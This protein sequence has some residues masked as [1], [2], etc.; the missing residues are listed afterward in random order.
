MINII[1]I[2][3]KEMRNN[4]FNTINNENSYILGLILLNI[5]SINENKVVIS[6]DENILNNKKIKKIL[7]EISTN[8]YSTAKES[9][10][11]LDIDILKDIKRH[12]KSDNLYESRIDLIIDENKLEDIIGLIRIYFEY[13]GNI[14]KRNDKSYV[15][16]SS[17]NNNIIKSIKSKFNIPCSVENIYELDLFTLIYNDAN[18]IDLL[19]NIYSNINDN[20]VLMSLYNKYLN[21]INDTKVIQTINVYK[22]CDMAILPSKC[23]ESDAGYDLTII[24]EIKKFNRITTLYDTG[25]KLDIPNGYYVEVFPR[26]SLSKSGYMLANSVGIID[27][28]YKGNIMIAL[29]KICQES[30]DIVLPFKCCQMILKKQIYSKIKETRKELEITERNIGGFGSTNN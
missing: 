4:Y 19:G 17:T 7:R 24:S 28:G 14:E 15:Y 27:Q 6:I 5:L 2:V 10:F 20:Y 12:I 29:T 3:N 18:C 1:Y 26:S 13:N 30:D 21:I 16:I 25:I 22:T 23:R 8:Y 9:K 11:I